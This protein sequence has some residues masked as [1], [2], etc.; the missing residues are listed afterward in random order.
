M[1]LRLEALRD[2]KLDTFRSLLGSREFGG[3]FC[4]V[5]TTYGDDWLQRCED[6]TQ[7]NFF[8]TKK[9]IEDGS[10]VGY[11]VYQGDDLVGWTG[12]GP[13]TSLV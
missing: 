10:H 13:K 8:T 1:S 9:N 7:P 6:K 11:F 3:C 2:D 5:W 4:A 12:S